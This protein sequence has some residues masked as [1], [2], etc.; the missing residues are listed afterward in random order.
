MAVLKTIGALGKQMGKNYFDLNLAI[1]FF[2]MFI[3]QVYSVRQEAAYI[4][5]D[6]SREFGFKWFS[7]VAFP[8]LNALKDSRRFVHRISYLNGLSSFAHAY[9]SNSNESIDQN[10]EFIEKQIT[11]ILTGFCSDSVDGVRMALIRNL[12][13]VLNVLENKQDHLCNN[14]IPRI[15]GLLENLGKDKNTIVCEK[16]R[17]LLSSHAEDTRYKNKEREIQKTE[18]K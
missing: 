18:N 13:I 8:A 12:G 16:A 9:V 3:D 17:L 15:L 7:E 10:R 14:I 11:P 2:G 4:L 6:I 1:S 5:S